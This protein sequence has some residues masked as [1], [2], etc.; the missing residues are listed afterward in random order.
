MP[1]TEYSVAPP[2]PVASATPL[3]LIRLR[4]GLRRE[5]RRDRRQR[6]PVIGLGVAARDR[7]L[8]LAMVASYDFSRLR[9]ALHTRSSS[10]MGKP[11]AMHESQ[12]S[13]CAGKD[14][15]LTRGE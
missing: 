6:A 12:L 3:W 9:R 15:Q 13:S 7:D 14:L 1:L 11:H 2:C 4:E 8:R 10:A 5:L